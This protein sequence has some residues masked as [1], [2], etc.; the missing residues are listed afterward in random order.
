MNNQNALVHLSTPWGDPR[1]IQTASATFI[2]E[3]LQ[4]NESY[5][6]LQDPS[7]KADIL[8]KLDLS[9]N[10]T[11]KKFSGHSGAQNQGM[12]IIQDVQT[13]SSFVLKLVHSR[14]ICGLPSEAQKLISV[15]KEH[16]DIV[17]DAAVA[18]PV[19]IFNCLGPGSDHS[20]DFI[21]LRKVSG[22]PL[23]DVITDHYKQSRMREL[24]PIL[25]ELGAF[26]AQ[27]HGRYGNCQHGDFHASNIFY[28]ASSC[29]FTLID[30]ADIGNRLVKKRDAAYFVENLSKLSVMREFFNEGK[31]NF[32]E[33]YKNGM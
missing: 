31:C 30:V 21:V 32:E 10:S 13:Q 18:F 2:V 17:H 1:S 6:P 25:R 15:Y 22:A 20:H 26:L 23:S 28:D 19:K 24:M 9:Q 16:P 27:F 7:L 11:L 4:V 3:D 8:S 33:G 29:R 12:W 14:G 5:D